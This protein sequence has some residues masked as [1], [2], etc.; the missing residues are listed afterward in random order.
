MVTLLKILLIIAFIAILTPVETFWFYALSIPGSIG[1]WFLIDF[2]TD[3]FK[4]L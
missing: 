3:L 1:L 4:K 2:L